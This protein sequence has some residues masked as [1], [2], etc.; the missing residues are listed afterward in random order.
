MD[1][2]KT[3][4]VLGVMFTSTGCLTLTTDPAPE[5]GRATLIHDGAW[6]GMVLPVSARGRQMPS[7]TPSWLIFA[8]EV[9]DDHTVSASVLIGERVPPGKTDDEM[10]EWWTGEFE[11]LLPKG[12]GREGAVLRSMERIDGAHASA[13]KGTRCVEYV[14][15]SED[16]LVP[17]H[18]GEP[19][20]MHVHEYVCIHPTARVV[21]RSQFSERF[22]TER[23]ELRPTFDEDAAFFFDSIRFL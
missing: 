23:H 3:S 20:I 16:R 11:K 17:G 6:V 4:F 14:W 13:P 7:P 8:A 12:P 5:D 10:L 2:W 9:E 21:V 22:S 1:L 15:V 18:R 19:F